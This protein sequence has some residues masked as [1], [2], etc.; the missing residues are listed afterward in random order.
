MTAWEQFGLLTW[1]SELVPGV[2]ANRKAAI[3]KDKP[4]RSFKPT[5]A[6]YDARIF[7]LERSWLPEADWKGTHSALGNYQTGKL[8]GRKPTSA[9]L[10]KHRDGLYH[11]HIQ[12]TD[13]APEPIKSEK[14]LGL[15]LAEEIC[16]NFYKAD[17]MEGR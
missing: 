15:T 11:L 3:A 14:W 9:Q 13:E 8:K 17:G 4:V 12:L 16:S 1:Q 2:G 6:D 5:S 7:A 10:C